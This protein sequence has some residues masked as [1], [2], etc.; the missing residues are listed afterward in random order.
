M[1]SVFEETQ[2]IQ[3]N[4]DTGSP[5]GLIFYWAWELSRAWRQTGKGYKCKNGKVLMT[6]AQD[7][8]LMPSWMIGCGEQ[9]VIFTI[10]A[11]RQ[12]IEYNGLDPSNRITDAVLS[13]MR[14]LL[15]AGQFNGMKLIKTDEFDAKNKTIYV[16]IVGQPL[17]LPMRGSGGTGGRFG[18]LGCAN[19]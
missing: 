15:A 7:A 11:L 9:E 8:D 3:L 13:G 5:K 16:K 18:E 6:P 19:K 2:E 10:R 14:G 1:K 4:D 12:F 17:N